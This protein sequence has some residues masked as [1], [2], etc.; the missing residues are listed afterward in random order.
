[1]VQQAQIGDAC[2]PARDIEIEPVGWCDEA[3][4]ITNEEDDCKMDRI[5]ADTGSDRRQDDGARQAFKDGA[6]CEDQPMQA[7][8]I[9]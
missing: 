2:D 1:M 5:D 9:A 6:G 8:R 3:D 7:N 4:R